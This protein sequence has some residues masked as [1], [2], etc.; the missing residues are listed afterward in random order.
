MRNR[1]LSFWIFLAPVLIA[2]TAVLI[3]PFFYGV[4]HSFTDWNGLTVSEFIGLQ[5]YI[6]LFRDAEFKASMWFTMKIA[7]VSIITINFFGL[8]LALIV[9]SKIRTSNLLRTIFFMPNLIGGLILGFIWQFIFVS[10]FKDIGLA[11]GIDAL[12]GFLSTP[13]TGFW[14]LII[15]NTWQW[16]GYIMIIYIA[17]L[18]NIPEDLMEAADIDGANSFKKFQNI[19]FPLLAPAFTVSLFLTLSHS[20]KI[21]DQNL[22][23]TNGGPYNSTKMVAMDIYNTAFME[24]QVSYGQSKGVIFFIVVAAIALLQAYYNKKQE[25]DV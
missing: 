1:D 20:F 18:Q 21:Y 13:K 9:T 16:A 10:V 5:N 14:G 17:Y 11:L 8:G 12:T 3:I 24:N 4:I 6:D 23:L 2:L 7:F 15:L 19:T 22:A 25:V